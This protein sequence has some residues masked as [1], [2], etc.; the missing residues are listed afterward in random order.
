VAFVLSG[1][2]AYAAYEIGVMKAIC[3]GDIR[4]IGLNAIE[5]GVLSGTSAGALNATLM[6]TELDLGGL[7]ALENLEK[8]WRNELA[9]CLG[10]SGNGVYR[11]R[12]DPREL[13]SSRGNPLEAV[14]SLAGDVS[15]LGRAF[16]RRGWDLILSTGPPETKAARLADVGPLISTDRLAATLRRVI[17]PVKIRESTCELRV[18]AVDWESG[19]LHVFAK[20][21]MLGDASCAI[22]LGSCAIPG[23]FPPVALGQ[24]RFAD[25]GL[26]MNTP[27]KPA[28]NAGATEIHV[29]YLDPEIRQIPVTRLQGT[30]ET[31][32]RFLAINFAAQV[33]QDLAVVKWINDSLLALRGKATNSDGTQNKALVRTLNRLGERALVASDYRLLTI[34]CYHPHPDHLGTGLQILDFSRRAIDR[35]I[36]RG[37]EDA[38]AHDCVK[39]G[40]VR[41]NIT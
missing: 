32:E 40:C 18:A 38:I 27:L 23:F 1:G 29:V 3:G 20:E 19:Q 7:H 9:G 30:L 28:I 22:L 26:I 17:D 24:S 11:L 13:F 15:T 6:A 10:Q 34:H 2:G 41:P 4:A 8:V 21:E 16:V 31:F 36:E 39:S 25:G 12:L 14:S 37:Y 35:L 5:P 33:N